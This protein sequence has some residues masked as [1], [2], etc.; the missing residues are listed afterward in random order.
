MVEANV[1]RSLPPKL[2]SPELEPEEVDAK[3]RE[4]R[5]RERKRKREKEEERE[6]GRE[7]KRKREKEKER[8]R[9]RKTEKDRERQRKTEK[10]RENILLTKFQVETVDDLAW[11]HL[12]VVYELLLQVL[13][14]PNFNKKDAKAAFTESF[15]LHLLQMFESEDAREVSKHQ[16]WGNLSHFLFQAR[17]FENGSA[18]NLS[19]AGAFANLF[20][21]ANGVFA[22][23]LRVSTS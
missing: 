17:L 15:V 20:A 21:R 7:R 14:S 13:E 23:R 5:E 12:H 6:R 2:N 8:E 3:K 22:A 9:Q 16:T 18:Q 4:R 19:Q 10:D 1:W 11:P